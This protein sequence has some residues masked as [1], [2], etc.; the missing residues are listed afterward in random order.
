MYAW[1]V[2]DSSTATPIYFTEYTHAHAYFRQR[3][4]FL[5]R[6]VFKEDPYL[7]EE[8]LK[9]GVYESGDGCFVMLKLIEQ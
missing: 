7:L 3:V 5:G 4:E 9:Y 2:E 8:S 1:I 6:N